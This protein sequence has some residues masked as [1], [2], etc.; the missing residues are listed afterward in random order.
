M[1]CPRTCQRI[2]GKKGQIALRWLGASRVIQVSG[3]ELFAEPFSSADDDADANSLELS[4]VTKK[5]LLNKK[6]ELIT[7]SL[8]L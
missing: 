6:R 8:Q 3:V 5:P 2:G 7:S 1:H 4:Q